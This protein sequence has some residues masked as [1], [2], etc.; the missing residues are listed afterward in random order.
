[1]DSKKQK[2]YEA[3]FNYIEE[4]VKQLNPKSFHTDYE[5][6][7]RSALR[8]VYANVQLKGCWLVFFLQ[9]S[10]FHLHGFTYFVFL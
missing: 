2:C 10:N 4:R 9:F 3:I 1:M 8:S 5:A 6:G 7:L